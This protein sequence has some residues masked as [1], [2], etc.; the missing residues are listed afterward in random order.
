MNNQKIKEN[1]IKLPWC[2]YGVLGAIIPESFGLIVKDNGS[3]V[4]ICDRERDRSLSDA[5]LWDSRYVKRF[6]TLEEALQ[7]LINNMSQ[8]DIRERPV[9]E[10]NIRKMAEAYF[11][12][13]YDK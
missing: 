8:S 7:F 11:L 10:Q 12:S 5:T 13:Q 9:T 3:T 1:E 4:N 6:N 2:T